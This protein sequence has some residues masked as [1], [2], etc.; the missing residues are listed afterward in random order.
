MKEC[1]ACAEEIKENA[2]LCRFCGIRQ[3]DDSYGTPSQLIQRATPNSDSAKGTEERAVPDVNFFTYWLSKAEGTFW[4]HEG[5]VSVEEGEVTLSNRPIFHCDAC[6]QNHW[7]NTRGETKPCKKCFRMP[8]GFCSVPI[9]AGDGTYPVFMIEPENTEMDRMIAVWGS[10]SVTT[11][12]GPLPDTVRN[13]IE[14]DGL[15]EELITSVADEFRQLVL[16]DEIVVVEVSSLSSSPQ[17]QIV[18][19]YTLP[20]LSLIH[21]ATNRSADYLDGTDLCIPLGPSTYSV[22]VA[23]RRSEVERVKREREQSATEFFRRPEVLGIFLVNSK[24]QA[25]LSK[26]FSTCRVENESEIELFSDPERFLEDNRLQRGVLPATWAN[27]CITE[28]R[29]QERVKAL[30]DRSNWGV[31]EFF[32]KLRAEAYLHQVWLWYSETPRTLEQEILAARE[33]GPNFEAFIGYSHDSEFSRTSLTNW[34][35]GPSRVTG[36]LEEDS[37][38]SQSD[39]AE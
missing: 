11:S 14:A 36:V 31:W 32:L 10:S 7:M 37:V 8:G 19:D 16:S 39:E 9:G 17:D 20:D 30:T 2:T 15:S 12:K 24:D 5:F 27:W 34:L 23:V 1:I 3:D 21:V 26:E 6:N 22:L 18:D 25:D 4:E 28:Y 29:Q 38:N 13:V 33:L 35:R